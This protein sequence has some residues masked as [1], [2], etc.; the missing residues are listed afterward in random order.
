[1]TKKFLIEK[2]GRII[3]DSDIFIAATAFSNNLI[4]VTN[5]EAHFGRIENLIIENWTS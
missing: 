2:E 4:L 1:M 3:S 5:N